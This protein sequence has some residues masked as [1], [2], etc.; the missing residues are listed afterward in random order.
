[1]NTMDE[2]NRELLLGF[3]I[4]AL[5]EEERAG[6][7]QEL[8]RRPELR[9]EL[10]LLKK[11][12]TP[13]NGAYRSAAFESDEPTSRLARRTCDKIWAAVDQAQQSDAPALALHIVGEPTVDE[14]EI[15]CPSAPSP[16]SSDA[17]SAAALRAVDEMV[18]A[19]VPTVASVPKRLARRDEMKKRNARSAQQQE[20]PPIS[21]RR[22]FRR[23]IL[24][25]ITVGMLIAVLA[26][27]TVNFVKN[28]AIRYVTQ[29][30]V[31]E[32]NQRIDRF[33]LLQSGLSPFA[34]IQNGET[35][36]PNITNFG[37][38]EFK[39]AQIPLLAVNEDW[40]NSPDSPLDLAAR[41]AT[42]T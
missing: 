37:W 30:Q 8:R 31:Q 27:P 26:F 15:L 34:E 9:A 28:R 14:Q 11:E 42:G 4:D 29:S 39:P 2:I 7:A 17:T 13:L 10:A 18:L 40:A 20:A 22:H 19:S 35:P 25:S 12:L 21:P 32:I 24:V 3:L 36:P 16:F 33:A 23:D 6:V 41:A 5:D 38:Q 1:M